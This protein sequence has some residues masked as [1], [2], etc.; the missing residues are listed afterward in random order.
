M[1]TLASLIRS[2]LIDI[3]D[4]NN[5]KRILESVEEAFVEAFNA[6]TR[7]EGS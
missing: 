5:N 4:I 7:G 1:T 6:Y 2:A 3:N